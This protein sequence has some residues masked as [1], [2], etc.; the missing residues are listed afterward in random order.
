M[1]TL[2]INKNA[3]MSK[4]HDLILPLFGN[5]YRK[6]PGITNSILEK[7][8]LYAASYHAYSNKFVLVLKIVFSK[9]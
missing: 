2:T 4:S 9:I 1:I 7:H 6:L 8:N 3:N 5:I